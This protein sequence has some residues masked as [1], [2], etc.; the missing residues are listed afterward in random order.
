MLNQDY[1]S[2]RNVFNT[3]LL[4]ESALIITV[5]S[6]S[7]ETEYLHQ[8]VEVLVMAVIARPP[9]SEFVPARRIGGSECACQNSVNQGKTCFC[10]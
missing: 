8:A 4:G 7:F 1:S 6:L 2:L 3:P 10:M 5:F 9:Q